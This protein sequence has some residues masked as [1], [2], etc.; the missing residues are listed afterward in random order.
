MS[1]QNHQGAATHLL[2]VFGWS[3]FAVEENARRSVDVGRVHSVTRAAVVTGGG[4]GLGREM[5]L[6][7]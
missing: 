4:S 2:A 6:A 5:A 1:F 7:L 3:P